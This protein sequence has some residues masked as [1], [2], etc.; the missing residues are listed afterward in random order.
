MKINI[1]EIRPI[2]IREVRTISF[3]TIRTIH[4]LDVK[5]AGM[6]GESIKVKRIQNV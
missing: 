2:N 4:L 3:R 1:K 6:M 5:R